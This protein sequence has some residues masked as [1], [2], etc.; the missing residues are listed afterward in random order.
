[1]KNFLFA[2]PILSSLTY[3]AATSGHLLQGSYQM[4][5]VSTP[6]PEDTPLTF[7]G[8]CISPLAEEVT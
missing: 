4:P 8:L 6:L 3:I 2:L 7:F 5:L 1:M